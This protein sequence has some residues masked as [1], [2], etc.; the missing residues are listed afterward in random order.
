MN[1]EKL[2]PA[3][4]R[5]ALRFLGLPLTDDPRAALRD[6]LELDAIEEL[7]RALTEAVGLVKA[8]ATGFVGTQNNLTRL[9]N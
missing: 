3:Q 8:A 5:L 6:A 1:P 7:R 4:L 9:V 2:N